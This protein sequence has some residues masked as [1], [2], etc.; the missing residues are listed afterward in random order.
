M[1]ASQC[2]KCGAGVVAGPSHSYHCGSEFLAGQFRPS[3][4]CLLNAAAQAVLAESAED[5]MLCGQGR[6][7]R[8][9]QAKQELR[10]AIIP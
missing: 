1:L 3:P 8:E 6:P 5:Y 10:R 4:A 2:P 9:C 7:C